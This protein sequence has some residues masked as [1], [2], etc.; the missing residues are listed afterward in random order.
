MRRPRILIADDDPTI[1]RFLKTNLEVRD[2]ET[3][4]AVDG[5]EVLNI[6]I[7]EPSNNEYTITFRINDQIAERTVETQ[8]V[9]I[10]SE[11]R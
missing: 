9:L 5:A 7:P 4:T 11:R 2:Y 8:T 3:L 6:V 10:I 1:L